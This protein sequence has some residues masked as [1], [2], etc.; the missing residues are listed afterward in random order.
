MQRRSEHGAED[1]DDQDR[2]ED[3]ETVLDHTHPEGPQFVALPTTGESIS[4]EPSEEQRNNHPPGT[5]PHRPGGRVDSA[6]CRAIA[7]NLARMPN[8]SRPGVRAML[9]GVLLIAS[10][11]CGSS[12]PGLVVST[13]E[14]SSN[15]VCFELTGNDWTSVGEFEGLFYD[16]G[17][18][19]EGLSGFDLRMADTARL[20]VVLD[21]DVDPLQWI[22]SLPAKIID[23][24]IVMTVTPQST[25]C[26]G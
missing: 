9:A 20:N 14:Q 12:D 10:P 4:E 1:P 3:R 13:S 5:Y 8:E 25:N 15:L 6:W 24:P 7:S 2:N 21:A 22:A 23:N 17:V 18:P 19:L 26:A 16:H 11:G